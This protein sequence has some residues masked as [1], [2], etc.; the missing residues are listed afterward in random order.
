M[1]HGLI[2]DKETVVMKTFE[3]YQ[4]ERTLKEDMD[5]IQNPADRFKLNSED[6]MGSDYDRTLTELIK[7]VMNKYEQETMQFL[8]GIANRGDQEISDLV[9]KI[10]K[11]QKSL[12]FKE[13][14]HPTDYD[15]EV[16]PP[17]ADTGQS[18]NGE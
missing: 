13:P 9:Q 15:N 2:F 5:D 14:E 18:P 12:N 8:V 10:S 6:E 7:A 1:H 17:I 3:D 4:R 11:D 16:V